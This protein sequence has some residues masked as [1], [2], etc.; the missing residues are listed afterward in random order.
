[1]IQLYSLIV[2]R[3]PR[4]F[5]FGVVLWTRKLIAELIVQRFG[6][7]L[8]LRTVGPILKKLG[9][10]PQRPLYRAYQQAPAKVLAWKRETYP[11]IRAEAGAV[12]ATISF[13][14]EA[15]VSDRPPWGQDLGPGRAHA[16]GHRDRGNARP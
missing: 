7:R 10:S 16:R 1:M 2:G 4:Q 8:S 6:V 12:G 11:T 9:M 15:G 13:A 5:S 3:D 14:E